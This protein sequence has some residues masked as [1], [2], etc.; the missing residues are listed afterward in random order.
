[1]KNKFEDFIKQENHKMN[2]KP[3][4]NTTIEQEKEI[5]EELREE[6]SKNP[7]QDEQI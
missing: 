2:K 6:Q 1:M 3:K 4:N 7:L 5:L